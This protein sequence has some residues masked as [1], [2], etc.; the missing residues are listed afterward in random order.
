MIT[1]H[2]QM[3]SS[4]QTLWHAVHAVLLLDR[5]WSVMKTA[6]LIKEDALLNPTKQGQCYEGGRIK[7]EMYFH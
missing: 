1:E 5:R 2:D 6:G 4:M 3:S 7:M